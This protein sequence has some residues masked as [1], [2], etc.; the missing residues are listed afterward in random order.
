[1]KFNNGILFNS[2]FQMVIL[3]PLLIVSFSIDVGVAGTVQWDSEGERVQILTG[4]DIIYSG[5]N[6]NTSLS[7]SISEPDGLGDEVTE[8]DSYNINYTLHD[9]DNV[10]TVDFYYDTDNTG[11]DGTLI[12]TRSVEGTRVNSAWDTTGMVPGTYY[13]Y[14]KINGGTVPEVGVYSPGPLTIKADNISIGLV[15]Y[16]KF[17]EGSGTIAW[18]SSVSGFDG[19]VRGSAIWTTGRIGGALSFG[20]NES[21]DYVDTASIPFVSGP[22]TFSAWFKTSK[23]DYQYIL[24]RGEDDHGSLAWMLVAWYGGVVAGL[25]DGDT[26]EVEGSKSVTDGNWHHAAAV[27]DATKI[28]LFVDGVSEGTNTHDNEFPVVKGTWQIG[29]AVN[30]ANCFNGAIDDVRIYN[31]ALSAQEVFNL[32]LASSPV[33]INDTVKTDKNTSITVSVLANDSAPEDE[34]ANPITVTISTHATHGQTTFNADGT[35]LYTPDTGFSGNDSFIYAITDSDGNTELAKVFIIVGSER[36]LVHKGSLWDVWGYPRRVRLDGNYAYIPV[37]ESDQGIQIVD[38]TDPTSPKRAGGIDYDWI[39]SVDAK[40]DVAFCTPRDW[41]ETV[42]WDTTDKEHPVELVLIEGNWPVVYGDLLVTESINDSILFNISNPRDPQKLSTIMNAKIAYVAGNRA[43][44]T[45]GRWV[46]LTDL[47]NPLLSGK[48]VSGVFLGVVGDYVYFGD[49]TGV[50]IYHQDDFTT[51]VNRLTGEPERRFQFHEVVGNRA[52]FI[53]SSEFYNGKPADEDIDYIGLWIL[54]VSDPVHP[55]VVGHWGSQWAK[56][57]GITT[58]FVDVRLR[59]NFAYVLN[60]LYGLHIIDVTDAANIQKVADYKCGGEINQIRLSADKKRAYLGEYNAGGVIVVDYEDPKKPE[61]L[62]HLYTGDPIYN[63][64]VYKDSFLYYE[65]WRGLTVMNISDLNDP[66]FVYSDEN[67]CIAK[68][69]PVFGD[70]LVASDALY[71]LKTDPAH[72]QKLGD[73]NLEGSTKHLDNYSYLGNGNYLYCAGYRYHPNPK[74]PEDYN[75]R[76]FDISNPYKPKEVSALR[77]EGD[78]SLNNR[79]MQLINDRLYIGGSEETDDYTEID[80]ITEIDVSDPAKPTIVGTYRNL[81]GSQDHYSFHIVGK[82]LYT[83]QYDSGTDNGRVFDITEGLGAPK[84]L[85][86]LPGYYSW[87]SAYKG[88]LVFVTHFNGLDIYQME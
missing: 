71:D 80:E 56:D 85:Q 25:Y 11:L 48:T 34:P 50:N 14:S 62:A 27:I 74:I 72:P 35:I 84:L 58:D 65:S 22:F 7:L 51:P 70:Y 69:D 43:L 4:D 77:I 24:D 41:D 13:I 42:V 86:E 79:H 16:W 63:F 40:S 81:G 6:A 31:R 75:F 39:Y 3:I 37:G 5:T 44:C 18:D 30:S 83:F 73:F 2:L 68:P 53:V 52:Y 54:D 23:S 46:D 88:D 47:K 19:L 15:G 36:L 78:N 21:C 12:S 10:V 59:G 9:P 20:E 60:N 61:I 38:I 1:M 87:H 29:R 45:D 82:R 76:I 49:D 8:G 17:D 55:T 33:A 67:I 26:R 64:G 32:S 66:R 28:E 57:R